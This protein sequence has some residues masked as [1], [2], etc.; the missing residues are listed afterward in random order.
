MIVKPN[1]VCCLG[2][3]FQSNLFDVSHRSAIKLSV[4]PQSLPI[5]YCFPS[6]F[7]SNAFRLVSDL[8]YFES[9]FCCGMNLCFWSLGKNIKVTCLTKCE[10]VTSTCDFLKILSWWNVS[11]VFLKMDKILPFHYKIPSKRE[12]KWRFLYKKS[13]WVETFVCRWR[14]SLPTYCFGPNR[15]A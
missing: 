3:S 8:I 14:R 12:K 4:A 15:A 11:E 7:A 9:F 5:S 1:V 10:L 2:V 13:Q 6:N